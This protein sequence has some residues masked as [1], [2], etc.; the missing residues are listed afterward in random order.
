M[1]TNGAYEL[2]TGK[3]M[4]KKIEE[5]TRAA[6]A[7]DYAFQRMGGKYKARIL[8]HLREGILRYG[9]LRRGMPDI[10]PKMLTQALR[11][12]ERDALITRKV[13]H[14]VP[15]RVEYELTADGQDLLPAIGLLCE[16][17][18]RQ[19][20]Q[21]NLPIIYDRASRYETEEEVLTS[22]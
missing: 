16:W 14:E 4:S 9:E 19:M 2:Q 7:V 17:G 3:K 22:V 13:Y 20:K 10:T 6:C 1:D 5:L 11:E 15:P 8:F 12:L 18:K 21:R